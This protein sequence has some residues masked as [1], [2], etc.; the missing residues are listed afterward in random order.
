VVKEG[1]TAAAAAGRGDSKERERE[2]EEPEEEDKRYSC[3][4]HF[5]LCLLILLATSRWGGHVRCVVEEQKKKKCIAEHKKKN[6]NKKVVEHKKKGFLCWF[7]AAEEDRDIVDVADIMRGGRKNLKRE[8]LEGIPELEQGEELM[9]VIGLR[10][11]NLIEVENSNGDK[12]LC[13]LPAKFQKTIWIKMGSYVFVNEGNRDKA[14]E[15]G[16]K[17]TGTIS[18]VLFE[19]QTRAMQKLSSWPSHFTHD[20]NSSRLLFPTATMVATEAKSSAVT[21][22]LI[23]GI[24]IPSG[25]SD[26]NEEEDENAED[27]EDGLPPLEPNVNRMHPMSLYDVNDSGSEDGSVEESEGAHS[28]PWLQAAQAHSWLQSRCSDIFFLTLRRADTYS[29]PQSGQTC[30]LNSI[31][32]TCYHRLTGEHHHVSS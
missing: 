24:L 9:R 23:S 6:K 26:G 19:E 3:L 5:C 28:H 15:D 11:S 27:E 1:F 21:S 31:Q 25:R 7:G 14:V 13:L 8:A 30:T 18:R 10:G 12:T 2:R 17:V 32:E 16:S 22:R 29:W 4:L 20:F